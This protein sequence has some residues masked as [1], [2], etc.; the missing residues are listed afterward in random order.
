MSIDIDR[1]LASYPR[2]R[3]ELPPKLAT[4]YHDTYVSSREG[5][6]LLYR[7]T[8]SLEGWMHRRVASTAKPGQTVLELG[9][10]TL[11]HLPW[12][13]PTNAYDVVEPYTALYEG[14]EAAGRVR[15]FYRDIADVP[16]ANR[17]DRIISIAT[18][19]HV[20]DLAEA[21]RYRGGAA[22]AGRRVRR[23]NSLGGRRIVGHGLA[24]VGRSV[25]PFADRPQL[26]RPDAARARQR[27]PRNRRRREPLFP[28]DAH[29]PLPAAAVARKPL[30]ISRMPRRELAAVGNA[31]R[32]VPRSQV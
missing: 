2:T 25:I 29:P 3:P 23:G 12:E 14:R 22:G 11:N 15:A 18:L 28:P 4:I 7:I 31:L 5:R 26:R 24:D 13:P 6:G 27:R 32:G 9:A 17:Y 16:A 20:L 21:G 8:Q 30:H 1:L 10:G 19:E